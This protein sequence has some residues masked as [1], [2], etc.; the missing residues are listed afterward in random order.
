MIVVVS[1]KI[2]EYVTGFD[3]PY[4]KRKHTHGRAN[5]SPNGPRQSHCTNPK[6]PLY[7]IEYEIHEVPEVSA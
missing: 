1:T 6:S 5:N 7:G 3:C 4:C 2:N